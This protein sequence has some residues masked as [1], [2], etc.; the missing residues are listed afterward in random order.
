MVMTF[1]G[2]LGGGQVYIA[3]IRKLKS[4]PLEETTRNYNPGLVTKGWNKVVIVVKGSMV[5]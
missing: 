4:I 2:S 1:G 3:Q 5:K